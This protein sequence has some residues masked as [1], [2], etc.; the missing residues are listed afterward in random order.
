[1]PDATPLHI[2]ALVREL[3]G[4]MAVLARSGNEGAAARAGETPATKATLDARFLELRDE[5]AALCDE[6]PGAMVAAIQI[7]GAEPGAPGIR[8]VVDLLHVVERA[9]AHAA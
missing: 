4:M 3:E 1:M 8:V 9:T 2:Q 6:T 5:A 7:R